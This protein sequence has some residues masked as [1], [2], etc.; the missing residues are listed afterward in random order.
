M[1]ALEQAAVFEQAAEILEER[2]WWQGSYE[3]PHGDLCVLGAVNT[4]AIGRICPEYAAGPSHEFRTEEE[5]ARTLTVHAGYEIST[6]N[7]KEGR[8]AFEAIDLLKDTAKDL[9]N[10]AKPA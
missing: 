6:W 1:D 8:T 3:G 7:D 9:R 4:V 2:G 10:K 5:L